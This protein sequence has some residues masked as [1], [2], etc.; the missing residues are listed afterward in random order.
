MLFV[1]G[2]YLLVIWRSL[3]AAR[4]AKDRLGVYLVMG[5]LASFTFQV[6]YNIT[7]SAGLRRSRV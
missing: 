1:L 5:L 7:M 3:E 2:L 6:I 4:L